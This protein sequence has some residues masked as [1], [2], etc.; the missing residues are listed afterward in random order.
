MIVILV[1]SMICTFSMIQLG[2]SE[3]RDYVSPSTSSNIY[4]G[5]SHK[6]DVFHANI[7]ITFPYMP[8]DVIGLNLRDSLENYVND[9]YGEVHKHRLAA[10]GTDLGVESWAEKNEK[11]SAQKD[12]VREEFKAGQGCRFEG[13]MELNRVPGNFYISS[14]DW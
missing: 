7:D 12:R 8:C 6:S 4:I 10:D 5:T 3:I 9:Y 11:R 14:F 2:F 13:F 1:V